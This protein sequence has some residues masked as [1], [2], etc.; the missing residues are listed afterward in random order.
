MA[1]IG[2]AGLGNMGRRMAQ[3]LADAG[4]TVRGWN[5]SSV[6]V[7]FDTVTSPAELAQD[8]DL[9][10]T[11]L[12]DDGASEAVWF[13]NDE[14]DGLVAGLTG[15]TLALE[16][17]TVTRAHIRSLMARVPHL[18]AAPVV[19]TLPHAENGQLTVLL[20]GS[21]SARATE[22][23]TP[24]GRCIEVGTPEQAMALKLSI[25]ALFATQVAA[26]GEVLSVLTA[27]GVEQDRALAMLQGTPVFPPVLAGVVALMNADDDA[28][29]FPVSLVEKDVRY[30]S[31]GSRPLLSAVAD[32]YR[33]AM[34]AGFADR[35]IHG[36][37]HL[38]L[39]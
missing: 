14:Q 15:E 11:M 1:T 4:H 33:A 35:N 9:V 27:S 16:A 31:E 39:R 32:R 7:P 37:T 2:I 19:G 3:R 22:W 6:D 17:S 21:A 23:L 34:D 36:V 13:G 26:L 30:A 18:H 20:G 10:L 28:P 5:R 38:A 24:L 29:R 8:A 12:T 25:N